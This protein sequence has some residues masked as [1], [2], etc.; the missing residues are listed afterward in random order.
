MSK[1]CIIVSPYFPPST[2]A[3]VHRARHLAKHLPAVGWDPIVLCVDE[4]FH[5]EQLDQGLAR[6]VPGSVE[7]VKVPALS[8][9]L[10][11]PFGL[12][13]ISLRAFFPLRRKLFHLLDSRKVDCVLFTGSP[14]YPMLLSGCI[15]RTYSVPV[16]LD[17][18]DPWVSAWG[19]MHSRWSKSGL[20]HFLATILEPRV[21][22]HAS[23]ITSVSETQNARLASRYRWL[24]SS[25]MAAIPIG[26]DP[27][28]FAALHSLGSA[29]AHTEQGSE[30]FNISYVGTIWPAVLPTLRVF[31][32]AIALLRLRHPSVYRR[33]RLNFIGTTANPNDYAGYRVLPLAEE[34]GV[35]DV[36][37]EVPQRIPYLDAL[38]ALKSSDACMM[39]GS[40]EQHY[41]ASKIF[42]YLMSGRPFLS[43]FHRASSAQEILSAAGGGLSRC[44][45]GQNELD[46]L[47]VEVCDTLCLIAC[48]PES[49]GRSNPDVYIR[50][51]A[52][53]IAERFAEVFDAVRV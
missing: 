19:S 47:V 27:E 6:L 16:V 38:A 36:I 52:A 41:T 13:E 40:N 3:G 21:V 48:D 43:L 2:L 37:R 31:L 50:F 4:V 9:R 17:F 39:I 25:A 45:S 35:A 24:D 20:S 22:R 23:F 53:N 11:R 42:P 15:R 18:Q 1:T 12:G 46:D 5:E 8:A 51:S 32:R 44:F 30:Y 28:D 10:T 14:Y 7:V 33:I 26:S 29:S 49:L 34:E